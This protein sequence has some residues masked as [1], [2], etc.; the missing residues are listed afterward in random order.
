MTKGNIDR[1]QSVSRYLRS[2][3]NL[4]NTFTLGINLELWKSYKYL[5]FS[6]DKD[7]IISMLNVP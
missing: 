5:E 1:S 6:K 2:L 3:S 7:N 4:P